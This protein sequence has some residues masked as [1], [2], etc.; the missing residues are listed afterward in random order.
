MKLSEAKRRVMVG[1]VL[2]AVG[3]YNPKA[4]GP[5]TVTKVQGNGFWYTC[6]QINRAWC[7]WP[8]ASL[9][10]DSGPDSIVLLMDS[11]E[12][13]TTLTWPK[14]PAPQ[15]ATEGA[16]I[17][18]DSCGWEI[19]ENRGIKRDDPCPECEQGGMMLSGRKP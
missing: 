6:P 7:P 15:P 8:K 9:T 10:R 4:S 17:I 5:R 3:H 18:C 14:S 2:L 13:M 19:T 16:P 12:P 11:G 1:T